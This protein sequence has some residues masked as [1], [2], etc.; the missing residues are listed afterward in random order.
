MPSWFSNWVT[1]NTCRVLRRLQ[2]AT[3][4]DGGAVSPFLTLFP[5]GHFYSPIPADDDF[6]QT[7]VNE[8]VPDIELNEKGQERLLLDLS[9]YCEELPFQVPD[10]RICATISTNPGTAMPMPSISIP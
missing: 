7:A 2:R 8:P 10:N 5:P 6:Q 1:H 4:C 3:G 9:R